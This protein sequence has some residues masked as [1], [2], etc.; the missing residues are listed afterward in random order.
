MTNQFKFG[1][2]NHP[3][4]GANSIALI[5][6][7]KTIAAKGE[8][9]TSIPVYGGKESFSSYH[10]NHRRLTLAVVDRRF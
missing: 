7:T 10:A 6:D 3:W 2:E 5:M 1:D 8:L 9:Q 4:Y